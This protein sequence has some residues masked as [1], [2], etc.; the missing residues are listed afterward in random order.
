L[1]FC[2]IRPYGARNAEQDTTMADPRTVAA[3]Y[4]ASWKAHDFATFRSLLADDVTFRG[5]LGTADDAEACTKGIEGMSQIVTDI[6][7]EHVWV[8]GP[9][10]L[11]WFVLH[12]KDAE[13]TATANWQH[14][15]DGKVRRIVVTFDPRGLLGG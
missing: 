1:D 2:D 14:I 12:S 6:V 13:P 10:V 3:T 4:F 9:D 8:D 15:E 5:P 11:T 7:I